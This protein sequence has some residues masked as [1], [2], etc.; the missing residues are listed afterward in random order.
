VFQSSSEPAKTTGEPPSKLSKDWEQEDRFKHVPRAA[1][2]QAKDLLERAANDL[3]TG[4]L[5]ESLLEALG[6]AS[7]SFQPDKPCFIHPPTSSRRIQVGGPLNPDGSR[8]AHP[9]TGNQQQMLLLNNTSHNS[10]H[11]KSCRAIHDPK[12]LKPVL[13][14]TPLEVVEHKW[15]RDMVHIPQETRMTLEHFFAY[16]LY[17]TTNSNA[18]I[19]EKHRQ[20]F[21]KAA[22]ATGLELATD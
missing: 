6:V 14:G 3:Q 1:L 5:F 21:E 20:S 8:R 7:K 2:Q 13:R 15:S 10:N 22:A 11:V 12:L 17:S 19:N 18:L 4:A 16:Q 9:F